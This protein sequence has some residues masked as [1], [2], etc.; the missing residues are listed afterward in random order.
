MVETAGRWRVAAGAVLIQLCLGAIYAWSVFTPALRDAGWS[1]VQTQIVFSVSLATFAVVMVLAGRRL[2]VWGP[3]RLA[4]AGGLTLGAGY[5]IA[6]LGGLSLLYFFVF[7][8]S[9]FDW[10]WLYSESFRTIGLVV[11]VLAI[12]LASLSLVL[13]F[14]TIERGVQL[15]APK[16][17]EWY[18]AYSLMVTLIWLYIELLRL[19]AL[20]ARNR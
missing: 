15:G 4:V 13:D 11:T 2:A 10:G 3:R 8:M 12:I 6:G 7:V 14:G 9:L 20:L 18:M 16:D 5:V 19:L 1:K 17:L